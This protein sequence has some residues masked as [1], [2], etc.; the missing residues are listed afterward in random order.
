MMYVQS[1][2]ARNEMQLFWWCNRKCTA[3]CSW[4]LKHSEFSV[5]SMLTN[6][7]LCAHEE[8][9]G[10]PDFFTD[11][12]MCE[13]RCEPER[14]M[15]VEKNIFPIWTSNFLKTPSLTSPW[16]LR[17]QQFTYIFMPVNSRSFLP[18]VSLTLGST[19]Q[20][21]TVQYAWIYCAYDNALLLMFNHCR[22]KLQV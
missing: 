19:T 7:M 6:C 22:A 2:C 14:P 11:L 21:C 10:F 3:L 1:V 9:S 18:V 13:F 4:T 12:L 5:W 16:V 17:L 20:C 15:S 8:S